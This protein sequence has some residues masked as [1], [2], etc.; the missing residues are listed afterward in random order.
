MTSQRQAPALQA[1]RLGPT[2]LDLARRPWHYLQC[3]A[4]AARAREL[5]R[6]A[7]TGFPRGCCPV[8]VQEVRFGRKIVL[9]MAMEGSALGL[10]VLQCGPVGESLTR[11]LQH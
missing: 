9:L 5:Q 11:H 3:L 1:G 7:Q 8:F 4:I 2:F 6:Q 10:V